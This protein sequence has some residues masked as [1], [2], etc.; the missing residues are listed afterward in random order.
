VKNA[1]GESIES[2]ISS[3]DK[4]VALIAYANNLVRNDTNQVEGVFVYD[5]DSKRTLLSTYLRDGPCQAFAN[6]RRRKQWTLA[7]LLMSPSMRQTDRVS[8][9]AVAVILELANILD[10][11]LMRHVLFAA[12]GG[13]YDRAVR[14]QRRELP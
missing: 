11:G 13:E 3:D 2:S 7:L 1:N 4:S 12:G 10:A 9:G 5:M 8:R 6:V 14:L